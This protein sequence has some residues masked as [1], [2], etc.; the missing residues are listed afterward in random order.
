MRK[1]DA[2][3]VDSDHAPIPVRIVRVDS[4]GSSFVRDHRRVD[5]ILDTPHGIRTWDKERKM[6]VKKVDIIPA[7]PEWYGIDA[8]V[9]EDPEKE[10]V[11]L[12]FE[13]IIAWKVEII[14]NDSPDY[15]YNE[16]DTYSVRAIFVDGIKDIEIFR[17]PN[18]VIDASISKIFFWYR[19]CNEVLS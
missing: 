10:A 16:C 17:R 13:P 9:P 12:L 2:L 3:V 4:F 8:V 19:R 5:S 11:K 15:N 7:E 18:G 6:R 1:C 14:Y